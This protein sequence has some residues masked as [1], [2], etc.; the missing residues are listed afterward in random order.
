MQNFRKL[1]TSVWCRRSSSMRSRVSFLSSLLSIFAEMA[2]TLIRCKGAEKPWLKEKESEEATSRDGGC[3]FKILYLAHARD[4]KVLFRSTSG[5]PVAFW[6]SY[7]TKSRQWIA[8]LWHGLWTSYDVV[9]SIS[10]SSKSSKTTKASVDTFRS[11]VLASNVTLTSAFPAPGCH[12]NRLP[13]WRD[14]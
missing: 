5:I 13:E 11:W 12:V 1:S 8:V 10:A 3:F 7:A 6:I 4:C 9:F 2:L 14:K